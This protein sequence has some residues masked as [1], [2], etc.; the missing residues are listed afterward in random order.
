M[1]LFVRPLRKVVTFLFAIAFLNFC[2]KNEREVNLFIWSEY[3]PDNVIQAFERQKNIKVNIAYYTSNEEMLAKILAGSSEFDLAVPSDYYLPILL[4]EDQLQEIPKEN[5]REFANVDPYFLQTPYD[6]ENRYSIPY[7]AGHALIIYDRKKTKPLK[8]YRDLWRSDLRNNIVLLDDMRAVIGMVCR[9]LG[10]SW[11]EKDP[12]KL[13]KAGEAL[14]ALMPNVKKFDSD[15]PKKLLIEGEVAAGYVWGAEA[16]LA[17]KERPSLKAIIPEEGIYLW[18]D[19]LVL[20]KDAPNPENALEFI[21]YVLKEEVA[22][23][24][25]MA[26]PYITANAA[27]KKLLPPEIVTNPAIYPPPSALAK[28]EFLTEL[29]DV[30]TIYDRIWNTAR[31]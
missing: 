18:L 9:S 12:Q 24:I 27:A 23:Q 22:L 29:G 13:E 19:S 20:L 26:Y 7:M 11:N 15:S 31:R 14:K 1:S 30:L 16:A 3:I 6:P 17:M 28:G 21:D 8:S 10:Y 5:L 2:K 4:A 25:A